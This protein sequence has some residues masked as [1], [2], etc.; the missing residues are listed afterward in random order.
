VLHYKL[1]RQTRNG[2]HQLAQESRGGQAASHGAQVTQLQEV[3]MCPVRITAALSPVQISP[4]PGSTC[5]A[6]LSPQVALTKSPSPPFTW[7]LLG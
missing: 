2:V 3:N 4:Y 7:E 1:V 5:Y 6:C